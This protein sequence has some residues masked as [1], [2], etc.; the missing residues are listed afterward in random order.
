MSEQ[1]KITATNVSSL[2]S[3]LEINPEQLINDRQAEAFLGRKRS[4]IKNSRHTGKLGGVE[5]PRHY[6]MGRTVRYRVKDL[7]EWRDRFD[8][9][10]AG[11]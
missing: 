8:T 6:K 7:L 11:Q 4:T 10:A 5:A 9:Q 2:V 1:I 3:I